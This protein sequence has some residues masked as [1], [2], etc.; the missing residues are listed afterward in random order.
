MRPTLYQNV[1]VKGTE[2][3]IDHKQ[4]PAP[5]VLTVQDG[6]LTLGG[7]S[8]NGLIQ[9]EGSVELSRFQLL[10]PFCHPGFPSA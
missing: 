10:L 3:R 2:S 5:M 4:Y 1:H 7:D 8:F 6:A 9:W